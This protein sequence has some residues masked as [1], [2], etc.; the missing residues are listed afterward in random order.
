[1]LQDFDKALQESHLLG[2]WRFE[3]ALNR[4]KNGPRP[5]G[6]PYVWTWETVHAKLME[7]CRV[8]PMSND[9]RRNLSFRNPAT[10]GGAATQTVSI[11]MQAV[12]PGEL[13]WAHRHSIDALRFGVVGSPRLFTV[14]D[15]EHLALEAGDLVL[16]PAY[17][18]HDHRNEGDETGIWLD[19][20][21]T[22]MAF[23]LNQVFYEE[24]GAKAQPPR[25]VK[26]SSTEP[27]LRHRYAWRDTQVV[28]RAAS[29]QKGNPHEGLVLRYVNP[30]TG[31]A[32]LSTLDCTIQRLKPAQETERHRQTTSTVCYVVE[33]EGSSIIGDHELH[34]N[35]GDTF[36][37]PN[38]L[39]HRH[40]N[41][42]A[43]CEAILFRVSDA[44]ALQALG[45]YREEP[46]QTSAAIPILPSPASA[47][48]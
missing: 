4:A 5:Y 33:G 1:V 37:V 38:W 9:A 3:D 39:W 8:I 21:N 12:V 32:A 41:V 2:Q 13:C 48:R 11:G 46:L 16:T 25:T 6:I 20:L 35:T 27:P 28:L 44:P 31:G 15:G 29:G 34:W 43:T 42:S 40:I 14:V 30:V 7:A 47:T 36:C 22:P 19:V 17:S 45:L 18:W 23:A 24:F 26:A 10:N